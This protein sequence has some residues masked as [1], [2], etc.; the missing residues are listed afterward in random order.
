MFLFIGDIEYFPYN[1]NISFF[2]ARNV[3]K[4]VTIDWGLAHRPNGRRF[5]KSAK[6]STSV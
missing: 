6:Q 4:V 5:L 3:F 1:D 2:S